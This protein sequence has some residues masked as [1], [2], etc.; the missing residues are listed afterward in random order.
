[1]E[2]KRILAVIIL[3]T[4]TF[5]STVYSAQGL[6]LSQKSQQSYAFLSDNISIPPSLGEVESRYL[7]NQDKNSKS[8]L[9]IHIKDLHASP[10]IQRNIHK[11]LS[12]L[13]RK[14][15]IDLVALEG[16]FGEIDPSILKILPNA[17][18]N[19]AMAEHL[20]SLGELTGAELF[21]LSEDSRNIR[22][23]GV[24]D[25]TLYQRSFEIFHRVKQEQTKTEKILSAYQKRL[26]KIETEKL[27]EKLRI[28]IHQRRAWNDNKEHFLPY[29][30]YLKK[31]SLK[32]LRLDLMQARN[33]F[34]WPYLTRLLKAQ[35][36]EKEIRTEKASVENRNLLAS[37]QEKLFSSKKDFFIEGI[38]KLTERKTGEAFVEWL[39]NQ[40]FQPN[41]RSV[42]RFLESLHGELR[43]EKQS[44]ILYPNLMDF[45]GLLILKE[46]I[47]AQELFQ[48]IYHLEQLLE[49]KMSENYV[50]KELL[51]LGRH[52]SFF[53][54][55]LSLSIPHNQYEIYQEK[56]LHPEHFR[57]KLQAL[58]AE[59]VPLP[60]L[61]RKIVLQAEEFYL[62]T[63]KRDKTLFQKTL[64][65][66]LSP[67]SSKAIVLIAGG[68][69]SK[70]LTQLM[71]KNE[72]PHIVIQPRADQLQDQNLYEQVMS[73]KNASL[74]PLIRASSLVYRLLSQR[75]SIRSDEQKAVLLRALRDH[76]ILIQKKSTPSRDALTEILEQ[77]FNN[78]PL[79]SDATL[80]S[81]PTSRGLHVKLDLYGKNQTIELVRF[82][83]SETMALSE[84]RASESKPRLHRELVIANHILVSIHAALLFPDFIDR[85]VESFLV[86]LGALS[87]D[88]LVL[89]PHNFLSHLGL[90][91]FIALATAWIGIWWHERSHYWEAVKQ[92]TLSDKH[93]DQANE[94]LQ[95]GWSLK[96]I[97]WEVRMFLRAPLGKFPGIKKQG[98]SYEV[99]AAYNL[100][101]SAM[102]PAASGQLSTVLLS[103]GFL[104]ITLS[105]ITHLMPLAIASRI[106]L[107][108][109]VVTLLDRFLA[110]PGKLKEYREREKK[111]QEA[112]DQVQAEMRDMKKWLDRAGDVKK[113]M[114]EQ[115]IQEARLSHRPGEY[116][117]GPW[118]FRNSGMGGRHTE[119][120]YPES[121][122]SLQESMFI[123]LSAN[124]YE[125]AQEMTVALQNRLREIIENTEGSRVIGIGLEGGLAAYISPAQGDT[126]PELRLWR[127][128]KQAIE[129][130]GYIPGKDVVLALDGAASELEIAYREL[131]MHKNGIESLTPEEERSLTGQ[132]Y[133]WR[134]SGELVMSREQL[135]ELYEQALDEDIPIISI[136][137]AFAEDDWEGWQRL[138]QKLGDKLFIV[139]DDLVVTND[140]VIEKAADLDT[141][142]TVLTKA[143]QIGTLSETVSAMVTALGLGM[144]L[145]ISHRSKSPNDD[146]EAQIAIAMGSLGLKAGGGA[147]T[148]RLVKYQSV[149]RQLRKAAKK[150]LETD[151]MALINGQPVNETA[152][153]DFLSQ[154]VITNI[155]AHEEPTNAG[156]PTVGVEVEL[157]IPNTRYE[158]LFRFTGATP[159]GTSAGTGEAIHLV[160]SV[161][162]PNELTLRYPELFKQQEDGTYKFKK[163]TTLQTIHEKGD[164]SLKALWE[165]AGRYK[166]KGVL[167]A[168]K[169]VETIIS[170]AFLG[171][172]ASELGNLIDI[173]KKLLELELK[174]AHQRQKEI[175]DP[176]EV[177]QRKGNL[178]MNGILPMSLALGRL[179]SN[180]QG[181]ELWEEI[182]DSA[183]DV[184]AKVV[185]E[186]RG[187]DWQSI[188]QELND[189]DLIAELQKVAVKVKKNKETFY[190]L[191]RKHLGI[192][193]EITPSRLE[194]STSATEKSESRT[195]TTA[196]ISYEPLD[197]IV[198][199]I[200]AQ[201]QEIPRIIDL[202]KLLRQNYHAKGYQVTFMP[203]ENTFML[204]MQLDDEEKKQKFTVR[205]PEN[206]SDL[207]ASLYASS[208]QI[209]PLILHGSDD[210]IIEET[211]YRRYQLSSRGLLLTQQEAHALGRYLA[212][213]FHQSLQN[214]Q[215][216]PYHKELQNHLLILPS[217]DSNDVTVRFTGW[218]Q[219]LKG[220]G[221]DGFEG[222]IQLQAIKRLA[223]V[224]RTYVNKPQN[225]VTAWKAFEVRL[226]ELEGID[227]PYTK[228]V[229]GLLARL[230]QS[231]ID[232]S[233][234][235][236]T[237][238]SRK[239]MDATPIQE[240][241]RKW[242]L[243][244]TR[245][246]Q[247]HVLGSAEFKFGNP[248]ESRTGSSNAILEQSGSIFVKQAKRSL[249]LRLR[250][251]SNSKSMSPEVAQAVVKDLFDRG[252]IGA[253]LNLGWS[254]VDGN[255]AIF[256]NSKTNLNKI[257]IGKI[258]KKLVKK[259]PEKIVQNRPVPRREVR[260]LVE[261]ILKSYKVS[262][263][264]SLAREFVRFL[265]AQEAQ[266]INIQ[267]STLPG[268][269]NRVFG[270]LLHVSLNGNESKVIKTYVI[271][272]PHHATEP[273]RSRDAS[274]LNLGPRVIYSRE[275]NK[276]DH[277]LIVE[278]FLVSDTRYGPDSQEPLQDD[279][280][281]LLAQSVAEKI[282]RMIDPTRSDAVLHRFDNAPSHIFVV[283]DQ[284]DIPNFYMIDWG[285]PAT[286]ASD[287][288]GQVPE[289][290]IR[291][292][293]LW[294]QF[295]HLG[296]L[297]QNTFRQHLLL[298]VS[299]NKDSSDELAPLEGAIEA[300]LNY[301]L[302][303]K[304]KRMLKRA[305]SAIAEK[306]WI[307]DVSDFVISMKLPDFLLEKVLRTF[308][309]RSFPPYD[310]PIKT[311]KTLFRAELLRIL[312][313][314]K[315]VN[316]SEIRSMIP[317]MRNR[318]SVD[319][320]EKLE[321]SK[322]T[323]LF[324]DL[325]WILAGRSEARQKET[326]SEIKT[327]L[328]Q[329]RIFL[330]AERSYQD[331]HY[332][333][334]QTFTFFPVE[335]YPFRSFLE[336]DFQE[337]LGFR[338]NRLNAYKT[339][340]QKAGVDVILRKE[341]PSGIA[342]QQ[343]FYSIQET[344]IKHPKLKIKIMVTRQ[345]RALA[346]GLTREFRLLYPDAGERLEILSAPQR[347][348]G[349]QVVEVVNQTKRNSKLKGSLLQYYRDRVLIA[350]EDSEMLNSVLIGTRILDNLGASEN[351]LRRGLRIDEEG[352]VA[353]GI[354]QPWQSSLISKKSH[355]IIQALDLIGGTGRLSDIEALLQESFEQRFVR[356][357]A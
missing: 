202:E 91:L 217:K 8:P 108:A 241:R 45:M 295:E 48:E 19:Q 221:A 9:I 339:A 216:L 148:E 264:E 65:L 62:L 356:I 4:F 26:L 231:L 168:V 128:M 145:I 147:N 343:Y 90:G 177:A 20:V 84:S 170:D 137:D 212:D 73:G 293:L 294:Q 220:K 236:I 175:Q 43:R 307:S 87:A 36:I 232:P 47:N 101:V 341:I 124:N 229:H 74:E 61:P 289:L 274:T 313:A 345:K 198:E 352:K 114:K 350:S 122:I 85:I 103:L 92:R 197:T 209:G 95:T 182:R 342:R 22:F 116:V 179:I 334:L 159:L 273:S 336:F 40:S 282:H 271:K 311:H 107:G 300:A 239:L 251:N 141:I 77:A 185:A 33:Q 287:K 49:N 39:K 6:P 227:Q 86:P 207:E 328:K 335:L 125:D 247:T 299:A 329:L 338:Q 186:N 35:A 200:H 117:K 150:A 292:A 225:N 255:L 37:L 76:G 213:F 57:R 195:E 28:Y 50:E 324:N 134:H 69:H 268:M 120:E 211:L 27:S 310:A 327:Q 67:K 78:H 210:L 174:T 29:L 277:G 38:K 88:H 21:S 306:A 194:Q 192:Y 193:D 79:F 250:L 51:E 218:N 143:N 249:Q 59:L 321:G 64:N 89:S 157:G 275:K 354:R 357:S 132:Y 284:R 171:K 58:Q 261:S 226:K 319:L 214:G 269:G 355:A 118:G 262:D 248:L 228:P 30:Q 191:I 34:E 233:P 322:D 323:T 7:P 223:F 188:R 325:K 102:G 353:V 206:P 135:L 317:Q 183:L 70:G 56:K 31:I 190:P 333:S 254:R 162:E 263:H 158:S 5:Q 278:D 208:N 215:F 13:A 12:D 11:I 131:H 316:F 266:S 110:D 320:R 279:K 53:K 25:F 81:H 24:D 303:D 246:S 291:F 127:M 18:A 1:M 253:N 243:F 80:E 204:F 54:E 2:A 172:S 256:L 97:L 267:V 270:E 235:V 126:V 41:I 104:G 46:E 230:R 153:D 286:L 105:F 96:R 72:I 181:R 330:G 305:E 199:K 245:V 154:L 265:M 115:R 176:I 276:R 3:I 123:P 180:V 129:D 93:F 133:F 63:Q 10:K 166:G 184:M 44:L 178:G 240:E 146:M 149:N 237:T 189:K 326:H 280:I 66:A 290:R 234:G 205:K 259:Q 344:L 203:D 296:P 260:D 139:G 68:F 252:Y 152:V 15:Q 304:L 167:N 348:L 16:G 169:N 155:S 337:P 258:R 163:N 224:I 242:E 94:I 187:I 315:G 288:R 257:T 130:L 119:K 161:I 309:R 314:N 17:E 160:D 201:F 98:L 222:E 302:E 106:L 283:V 113:Y 332:V 285:K 156:I 272:E 340:S 298:L 109:G 173:D 144:E 308:L 219:P 301:S 142:D 75:T 83:D 14:K 42:R 349:R 71:R 32:E 60:V 52:L 121:N 196:T 297:F 55:L 318:F 23:Q 136:E 82:E 100:K 151:A 238:V 164:R 346:H 331:I 347:N 99:E 112:R 351:M 244:F 140:A 111:A 165:N 138:K 312:K 281:V